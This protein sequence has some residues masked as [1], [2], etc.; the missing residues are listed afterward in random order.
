MKYEKAKKIIST[1]FLLISS[2]NV[3]ILFQRINGNDIVKLKKIE[4]KK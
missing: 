4:E 2:K 3:E 1:F